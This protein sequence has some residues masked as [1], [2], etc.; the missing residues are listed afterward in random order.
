MFIFDLISPIALANWENLV[1]L[2]DALEC[3]LAIRIR[4]LVLLRIARLEKNRYQSTL[5]SIFGIASGSD[6]GIVTLDHKVCLHL[7]FIARTIIS[8]VRKRLHNESISKVTCLNL[9]RTECSS[10]DG[11]LHSARLH[12]KAPIQ[13]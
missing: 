5:F 13:F 7:L 12:S 4:K 9:C 10:H 1:F 11:Y 3:S 6:S 2:N 8:V